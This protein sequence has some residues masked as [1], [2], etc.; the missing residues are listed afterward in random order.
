MKNS[1]VALAGGLVLC[2]VLFASPALA[3]N[4]NFSR[5]LSLHSVGSDV[6]ALQTVL[7]AGGYF[8]QSPTGYFGMATYGALRAWQTAYHI[9]ST[10]FFGPLSRTAA[11]GGGGSPNVS[12][13]WPEN[14]ITLGTNVL[15][16]AGTSQNLSPASLQFIIDGTPYHSPIASSPYFTQLSLAAGNHTV[17]AQAIGKNGVAYSSSPVSFIVSNATS[18]LPCWMSFAYGCGGSRTIGGGGGG[19]TGPGVQVSIV[20]PVQYLVSDATTTFSAVVENSSAGVTW[21]AQLGSIDANGNYTA[22]T[23][24]ADPTDVITATSITDPSASASVDVGVSPV[25]V[26]DDLSTVGGTGVS[27]FAFQGTAGEVVNFTMTG[28]DVSGGGCFNAGIVSQDGTQIAGAQCTSSSSVSFNDLTLPSAGTYTAFLDPGTGSATTTFA[29]SN[30]TTGII[31]L[32]ATTTISNTFPGKTTDL[33]FAG[34]EGQIVSLTFDDSSSDTYPSGAP[35]LGIDDPNGSELTQTYA[36][37]GDNAGV[38]TTNLALPS[39]GTYTV[40]LNPSNATGSVNVHLATFNNVTGTIALN[41]AATISNAIPGQET[42][43]TFSGTEGQSVSLTFNNGS[44]DTYPSGGPLLGLDDTDGREITQTY[45]GQGN[46]G[47]VITTN[48]VL[49]S[50]GTYTVFLNPHNSVGSVN[51]YLG[52]FANATDTMLFDTTTT[53]SN[54][55]PGQISEFTFV[56]NA[57]TSVSLTFDNGSSDTYPSG[58]PLLGLDDTDGREMTQTYAGQGNSGG[59]ITTNTVLPSTGTYTVFLNPSNTTGSVNVYLGAFNNITSTITPNSTTTI[60]N[61]IP[62]QITYLSFSGTADQSVSLT[63]DNGSSDTYPSGG[64][65][66]GINDTNGREM[67]QTYAGQGNNGGIIT[68]NTVLPS[69]GTYT[70]FLNPSNS[71]GSVNVHFG[72]FNNVSSTITPNATTTISNAIPGQITYLSFSGTAGQSV[73]LTFDNGSSDTY[74][75]G[76]PLLGLDDAN[77]SYFTQT[78]AGQGNSSGIITTNLILPSTATYLV[79]LDP[80]NTVGSV[81]VHLGEFNNVSSTIAFNTTTTIS[82]SIPG[83]ITYLSFSGTAG[84]TVSLIFDNGSSD[85]YPSNGPLLGIDAANGGNFTQTY[86]GQGQNNGDHCHRVEPSRYSDL[87]RSS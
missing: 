52:G 25:A 48:T 69:T 17:V 13:I 39:T 80:H 85:T 51:I 68:T 56:A 34:T 47:G 82:N 4:V 7:S 24:T 45:A 44:S 84:Q 55:I 31:A 14:G 64:P 62:G 75:S 61:G 19:S 9:S 3:A 36:G 35:L 49:P 18:T 2:L 72:E 78:Y 5:N 65:L 1:V 15:L 67:T 27:S 29:L 16:Y 46:S 32:N 74:P 63:F 60:S 30:P 28:I 53:I 40:F 77:G 70:V 87:S 41:S 42:Y 50:T 81:N 26:F 12:M 20:P 23:V 10:G 22:P 8:K 76:G 83:Q 38:I 11:N 37:Q 59:I 58:G 33:T 71:V 6:T 79:A 73:S 43:L 21:S 57:G 54:T 66:L 86:A